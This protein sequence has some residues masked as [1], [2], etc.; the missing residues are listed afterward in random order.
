MA[1]AFDV[2]GKTYEQVVQES[3][4]FS[5]LMPDGPGIASAVVCTTIRAASLRVVSLCAFRIHTSTAED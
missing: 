3:I 5:G 4:S 2:Y 1:V